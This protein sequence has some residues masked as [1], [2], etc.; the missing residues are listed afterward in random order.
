MRGV[1]TGRARLSLWFSLQAH[2]KQMQAC[3]RTEEGILTS[4]AVFQTGRFRECEEIGALKQLN[5]EVQREFIAVDQRAEREKVSRIR[6]LLSAQLALLEKSSKESLLFYEYA[7][8]D[9]LLQAQ[10]FLIDLAFKVI[11][12]LHEQQPHIQE[13]SWA[14]LTAL[15]KRGEFKLSHLGF[16]P[17]EKQALGG[18]GLSEQLQTKV[19]VGLK[20]QLLLNSLL[21]ETLASLE[22]TGDEAERIFAESFCAYAYFRIPLLR[23]H[24]LAVVRR[25]DDPEIPE[26]RGTEF[27]LSGENSQSETADDFYDNMFDWDTHFW[28]CLASQDKARTHLQELKAVLGDERWKRRLARRRGA[29]YTFLENLVREIEYVCVVSKHIRW[30][31]LPGYVKLLHAFLVELRTLK[32]KDYHARF[33]NCC[34]TLLANEKLINV[35]VVV[36]L[37]KTNLHEPDTVALT[38]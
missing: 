7:G 36:L 31:R 20:Y 35:L 19:E 26:W 10:R 37:K 34:V 27:S 9:D 16:A 2:L 32:V 33:R 4:S 28:Q 17:A 5:E 8:Q 3:V 15:L 22:S 1:C 30:H 38:F 11:A 24:I 23:E 18:D 6:D 14:V 12:Y 25:A 29:F 13:L 21:R